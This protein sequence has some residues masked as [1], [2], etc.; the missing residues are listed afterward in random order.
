MNAQLH[1]P[2]RV[3]P[4]LLGAT[5]AVLL[6]CA[7]AV[8]SIVGVLPGSLPH[9]HYPEPVTVPTSR[10]AP[11]QPQATS[12]ANCGTVLVIRTYEVRDGITPATARAEPG[13]RPAVP[14]G[15]NAEAG[16]EPKPH[17]VYRVTVQMEDGS[18]RTISQSAAPAFS[19]GDRVRVMQGTL[20]R[21]KS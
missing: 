7:V 4:L 12:C 19:V 20:V 2:E 18:Y 13:T 1:G 9:R 5:L 3:S 11:A 6:F 21:H 16:A 17:N 14:A 8:G 10:P 15:V